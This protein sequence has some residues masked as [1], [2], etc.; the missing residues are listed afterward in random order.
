MFRKP[1]WM[2]SPKESSTANYRQGLSNL[3]V[4]MNSPVLFFSY[5]WWFSRWLFVKRTGKRT[6]TTNT[7]VTWSIWGECPISSDDEGVGGTILGACG[8]LYNGR[9]VVQAHTGL[10]QDTLAILVTYCLNLRRKQKLWYSLHTG[11]H[12]LPDMLN[13]KNIHSRLIWFQCLYYKWWLFMNLYITWT[14]ILIETS[15]GDEHYLF[16]KLKVTS[17]LY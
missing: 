1:Q 16:L 7:D 11:L 17:K 14:S 12:S 9:L 6:T 8:Y 2:K 13:R 10:G 5:S 15:S 3:E 4:Y